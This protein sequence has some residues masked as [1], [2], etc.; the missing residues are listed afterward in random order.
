MSKKTCGECKHFFLNSE[1]HC[2]S[3]DGSENAHNDT[4]TFFEPKVI[5]NGD[6]IR[7][8]SN[9]EFAR[10]YVHYHSKFKV[11]VARL[12]PLNKQ[13]WTTREEAEKANLGWLNAPADCV[14]KNGGSAKQADLC[15]K[16]AKESEVRDE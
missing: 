6:R 8:K 5:T 15:C 13:L 7:Q 2:K 12:C 3:N 16:S 14:A 1:G 11:Y 10:D 4:C 9:E